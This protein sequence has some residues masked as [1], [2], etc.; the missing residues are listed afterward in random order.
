MRLLTNELIRLMLTKRFLHFSLFFLFL[1]GN[2]DMLFERNENTTTTLGYRRHVPK[3]VEVTKA[4]PKEQFFQ[5]RLVNESTGL[6]GDLNSWWNTTQRREVKDLISLKMKWSFQ[7]LQPSWL[8]QDI[9]LE[10][11]PSLSIFH[12]KKERKILNAVRIANTSASLESLIRTP[13]ENMHKNIPFSS[14]RIP[15]IPMLILDPDSSQIHYVI[16]LTYLI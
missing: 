1:T 11:S 3:W 15:S 9:A 14:R 16:A 2:K 4:F 12:G 7:G 8:I 6:L 13:L 5:P 10:E